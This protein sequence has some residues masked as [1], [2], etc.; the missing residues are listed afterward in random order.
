[1]AQ[2][3]ALPPPLPFERVDD[4]RR[5]VAV[6]AMCPNP[7]SAGLSPRNPF[8]KVG[9]PFRKDEERHLAPASFSKPVVT[10]LRHLACSDASRS[11]VF[12]NAGTSEPHASWWNGAQ[13]GFA[14]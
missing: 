4:L 5:R 7:V 9:E 8:G 3:N 14:D 12:E 6:L 1:M 2:G 10:R 11:F 13:S